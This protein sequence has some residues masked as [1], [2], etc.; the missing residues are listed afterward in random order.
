MTDGHAGLRVLRVLEAAQASLF[1]GSA[2][3]PPPSMAGVA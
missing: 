2:P 3:M 1:N